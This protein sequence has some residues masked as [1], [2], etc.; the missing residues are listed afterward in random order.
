MPSSGH[1]G[2][3]KNRP[4]TSLDSISRRRR[5]SP[6]ARQGLSYSADGTL[7]ETTGRYGQ[8]KVL[9]LRPGAFN[10]ERSVDLDDR[11][12]GEG[13]A[14]YAEGAGHGRLT[15]LMWQEQTGFVCS[16]C[17]CWRQLRRSTTRKTRREC[18]RRGRDLTNVPRA[19]MHHPAP[20]APPVRPAHRGVGHHLRLCREGVRR[21]RRVGRPVLLGP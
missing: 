3:F 18:R 10:V 7:F 17:G 21:E 4:A 2:A 12:F 13:S 16:T 5:H 8:S 9:R 11:Y 6:F 20:R 19:W 1:I 15:H 14:F